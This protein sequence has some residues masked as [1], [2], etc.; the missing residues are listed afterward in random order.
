MALSAIELQLTL[1]YAAKAKM[2]DSQAQMFFKNLEAQ[3]TSRAKEFLDARSSYEEETGTG[4]QVDPTLVQSLGL[5]PTQIKDCKR[6]TFQYAQ[7]DQMAIAFF[8]GCER[9]K[10]AGI[11][12][13]TA[14]LVYRD[15]ILLTLGKYPSGA[16]IPETERAKHGLPAS[17]APTPETTKIVGLPTLGMTPAAPTPPTAMGTASALAHTTIREQQIAGQ[18][19]AGSADGGMMVTTLPPLTAEGIRDIEEAIQTGRV[20]AGSAVAI[21]LMEIQTLQA[22]LN[23]IDDE[24]VHTAPNGTQQQLH[25]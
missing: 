9:G 24:P 22:M 8:A 17:P 16:V 7:G 20:F 14:M 15:A 2:G 23:G 19:H 4:V 3:G 25:P 5:N 18:S 10:A 11:M 12:P 1:E 21:L 13:S 6:A